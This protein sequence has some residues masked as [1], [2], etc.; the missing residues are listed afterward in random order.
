MVAAGCSWQPR[1]RVILL[2]AERACHD[3]TLNG[4]DVLALLNAEVA[5]LGDGGLP[6]E[7]TGDEWSR[8]MVAVPLLVLA[9]RRR[10][11]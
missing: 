11:R 10:R 2:P 1:R 8:A 9:L 7:G 5:I 3:A 4:E 6:P